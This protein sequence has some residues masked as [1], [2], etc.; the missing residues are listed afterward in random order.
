M[1]IID[2]FRDGWD[3]LPL[4]EKKLFLEEIA[5]G[6]ILS[7][8]IC[9]WGTNTTEEINGRADDLINL[10][11]LIWPPATFIDLEL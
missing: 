11:N 4:G 7:Q 10:F 3:L 5:T 1:P 9:E 6:L 2:P 8:E